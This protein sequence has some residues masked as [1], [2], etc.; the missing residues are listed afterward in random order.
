MVAQRAEIS[1]Q[2]GQG[3]RFSAAASNNAEQLGD[4]LSGLL[5]AVADDVE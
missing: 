1:R 2:D 5:G 3:A 4:Q